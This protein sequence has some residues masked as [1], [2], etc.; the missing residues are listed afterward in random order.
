MIADWEKKISPYFLKIWEELSP[1]SNLPKLYHYSTG[2]NF[3]KIIESGELWATQVACLNDKQECHGYYKLIQKALKKRKSKKNGGVCPDRIY[4]ALLD[5]TKESIDK[6]L[7]DIPIFVACFSTESDDLSQWRAYSRGEEGY[8]IG[9]DFTKIQENMH[10]SFKITQVIYDVSEQEKMI[11]SIINAAEK[12]FTDYEIAKDLDRQL[13]QNYEELEKSNKAAFAA[14]A[15]LKAF[16][17]FAPCFKHEAYKAEKEWR[18]IYFPDGNDSSRMRFTQHRG[19]LARHVALFGSKNKEN[20]LLLPELI[21]EVVIGPCAY[22]DISRAN[23]RY[24]LSSKG[25]L[26]VPIKTSN[27]PFR[28]V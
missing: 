20:S 8:A 22:P 10:R 17:Q 14:I 1:Y 28:S 26:N 2:E 23:V 24:L 3:I 6:N 19:F 15:F 16:G 9:I 21:R 25:Y 11:E 4:Q 18:I 12:F 7:P 27:I 5:T 13:P